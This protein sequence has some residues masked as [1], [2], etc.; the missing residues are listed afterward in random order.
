MTYAR[1]ILNCFQKYKLLLICKKLQNNI[2]QKSPL[3][4]RAAL[5]WQINER[6]FLKNEK[7]KMLFANC[8]RNYFCNH[9]V[10]GGCYGRDSILKRYKQKLIYKRRLVIR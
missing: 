3:R 2:L 7:I 9:L 1:N 6:Y 10:D 5:S 4:S 8:E